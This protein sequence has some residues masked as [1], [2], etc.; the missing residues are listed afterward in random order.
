LKLTTY[1]DR[2]YVAHGESE[3]TKGKQKQGGGDPPMKDISEPQTELLEEMEASPAIQTSIE[4][5]VEDHMTEQAVMTMKQ[6]DP[7]R[8]REEVTVTPKRL[9]TTRGDLTLDRQ[10]ERTRM[11]TRRLTQKAGSTQLTE[12]AQ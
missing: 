5:N 6:A 7:E 10:Q 3:K 2:T 11:L 1:E 8:S 4:G 12:T 9:K